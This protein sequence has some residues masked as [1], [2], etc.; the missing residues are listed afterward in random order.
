VVQ[1]WRE[2][3]G[4]ADQMSEQNILIQG[5]GYEYHHP[6]G[7]K[8]TLEKAN[9]KGLRSFYTKWYK[10]QRMA[11][12]IVGDFDVG[13]STLVCKL[14]GETR[15]RSGGV[16]F[17]SI[18]YIMDGK[19]HA[20]DIWDTT[21]LPQFDAIAEN[22]YPKAEGAL[23]V[24]DITSKSSFEHLVGKPPDNTVDS[25]VD[26]VKTKKPDIEF[27]VVGNK[28]D[29]KGEGRAVDPVAAVKLCKQLGNLEWMECSAQ[30]GEGVDDA[31]QKL[32][33]KILRRK[34][35]EERI[36]HTV[37]TPKQESSCCGCCCCYQGSKEETKRLI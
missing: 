7:K 13:K 17:D 10:P 9:P 11:I 12:I 25:W 18:N 27:L 36:D 15:T 31:L 34:G 30:T 20:I 16:E 4:P 24:Y 21:G 19:S 8:E 14:T 2:S 26:K 3:Q 29:R 5:T 33:R 37:T 1:E 28:L 22:Y 23:M 6:I 32:L 35:E